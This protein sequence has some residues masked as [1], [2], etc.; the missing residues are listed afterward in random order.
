MY[1]HG[2]CTPELHSSVAADWTLVEHITGKDAL[3]GTQRLGLGDTVYYGF[4]AQSKADQTQYVVAIRGT[5]TLAEWGEDTEAFIIQHVHAGFAS[6]FDT[7]ECGMPAQSVVDGVS[8]RVPIGSNVTVVGH[9]LGAPLACYTLLGLRN[10]NVDASGLFYAMPKPGDDAFAAD[11]DQIIGRNYHVYDYLRDVV[12]HLP[13]W[14]PRHRFTPLNN[15]TV[16]R[17]KDSTAVIPDDIFSNHKCDSYVE[18]LANLIP[19][20]VHA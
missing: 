8:A 1:L 16:I 2:V 13:I 9:S 7:M 6:I 12:P 20:E 14:L 3:F 18:L 17:P 15:R 11:Y 4:L 5:E 10:M 19:T